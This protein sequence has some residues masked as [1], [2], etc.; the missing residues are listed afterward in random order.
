MVT[1]LGQDTLYDAHHYIFRSILLLF[2]PYIHISQNKSNYN[3]ASN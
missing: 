2:L 1:T 3:N